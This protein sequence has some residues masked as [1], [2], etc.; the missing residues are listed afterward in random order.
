MPS[1]DQSASARPAR[2]QS[3][4]DQSGRDQN[5]GEIGVLLV[6]L[7]TPDAA[8]APAVRRYLAEFLSDP[9][10]VEIPAIAWKP[11][12][13]GIILRTRPAKSAHA[14][15]QVWT[16]Q[17]SPLA[18]ITRAQ[19]ARLQERLGGRARVDWAMRYGNPSLPSQLRAMKDAGCERILVAP[20]YPQYCGAT[21]AS[22]MDKLGEALGA[23]RAQ[24]AIRTLPPYFDDPAYIDALEADLLRQIE[25]L[26]FVPEVLLLSFHGMPQRTADLGDP[27]YRHCLETSRLLS[28]RLALRRPDL[29]IE[30]SFQ[31]RFGRAKW[32]EPSTEDVLAAEAK[33]GTR[34]LAVAAPG[35]SADCVE[36]LEE[37]AIRGREVFEEAGG[38]R[39]AVL[40]CLN[41]G[42]A[43]MEMLEALVQRELS[44]W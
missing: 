31:S 9:R 15:A 35:F 13:Y 22:V 18:A 11:I 37:L 12:L 26:D 10:V 38:Q 43:G 14:Y 27:Y 16:P 3:G 2:N 32:L 7:G 29:R 8:T 33:A 42:E 34:R 30:T 19:A 39:I 20:L 28:A 41:D 40:A 4:S 1:R 23:M 6:N 25:A 24:P 21:T 44:G 5:V 36:T 17:G